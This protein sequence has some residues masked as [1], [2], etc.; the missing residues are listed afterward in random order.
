MTA[1]RILIPAL[2]LVSIAAAFVIGGK[3]KSSSDQES[4]A[5]DDNSERRPAYRQAGSSSSNA[6]ASRRGGGSRS[7]SSDSGSSRTLN[8]TDIA[9]NDDPIERTN[10]LLRLINR[11]GANDFAKVVADFRDLGI[12]RERMSEYG[13]LLHA[14]AKV[15]PL[16]AIEYAE[17]NTGSQYARQTILASWASHDTD[18]ALM[19][20]KNNHEGTGAN[21]WMIGIIRGI[22]SKD[23][24]RASQIM[25]ELPYSRER[26]DAISAIVP[27]IARQGFDKASQWL[28]TITDERLKSG[29][30]AYIASALAKQDPAKTAEWL[31]SL[32]ESEGKSRAT[33]EVAENWAE[34]D[35]SSAVAWTD[36][37]SGEERASAAREVIGIYAREDAAQ[38]ANWL[39]SISNDP[40]YE[41]V[42]ESYIWNTARRAPEMSLAQIP[43]IK[44]ARSQER[45]YERILRGW[46][47]R[48]AQAAETWMNN[49]E[50]SDE[51]RAKVLRQNGEGRPRGR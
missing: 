10:D 16:G 33:R 21:P 45:Y 30:T 22:V 15:D 18:S 11:L 26:G 42:V 13:M 5:Q 6:S 12:T 50:L 39:R 20:A 31:N 44:N 8:I 43:E 41:R 19:W 7:Q 2:W 40:G 25:Q 49:N 37:L 35:L 29:S 34:Q 24:V 32:E 48:D 38:A 27:H 36:T 46:H 1:T 9:K 4:T 51:I 28:D 47:G 23:P 17:K 3:I 14:W